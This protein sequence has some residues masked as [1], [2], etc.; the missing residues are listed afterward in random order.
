MQFLFKA[1]SRVIQGAG[2]AIYYELK[3]EPY[4]VAKLEE[5]RQNLL[6]KDTDKLFCDVVNTW[7]SQTGRLI[8]LKKNMAVVKGLKN[9]W[10]EM[11]SYSMIGQE[12]ICVSIRKVLDL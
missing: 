9:S 11:I 1:E 2:C 10:S 7:Y 12:P 6:N 8:N 4:I 3:D 5:T